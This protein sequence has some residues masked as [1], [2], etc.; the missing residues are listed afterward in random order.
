MKS[1]K[2]AF[3][4]AASLAIVLVVTACASFATRLRDEEALTKVKK[5]AVIAYTANLPASR[6]LS[7][8]V[9]SGKV[10]GASGGTIIPMNSAET[11]K[12]Y[13]EFVKSLEKTQGWKV[14]DAQTMAKHPAYVAAYKDTMEGWQNKMPAGAGSTDFNM[15]SVMD[16]NGPRI[17][18]YEGREKLLKDL[19]VDAIIMLK[20]NVQLKGMTVA[21][22]GARKPQANAHI[23]VYGKGV[24][25]QI[26]FD[27]FEGDESSESVGMTGF[28]NEKK[29][30][31]LSLLSAQTAFSKMG[32]KIN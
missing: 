9:G 13:A 27:S 19:G 29:L 6:S 18:K 22:I 20:V 14:L 10:G 3:K 11:D 25:K 23:E 21:G 1:F 12:M 24:E 16:W 15:A 30:G 32:S 17:M 8:D 5:V 7:L 31:E 26:W 28:I 2:E 4:T